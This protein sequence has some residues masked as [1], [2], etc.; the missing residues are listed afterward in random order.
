M[1]SCHGLLSPFKGGVGRDC[2]PFLMSR[3]PRANKR[4]SPPFH[5]PSPLSIGF[6]AFVRVTVH[7]ERYRLSSNVLELN[8]AGQNA[9]AVMEE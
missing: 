4:A 9:R 3:E 5:P 2:Y 6:T 8:F 1:K 7:Y